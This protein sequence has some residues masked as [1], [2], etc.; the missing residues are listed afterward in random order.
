MGD[1]R[2]HAYKNDNK[3]HWRVIHV[4]QVTMPKL[5]SQRLQQ[6]GNKGTKQVLSVDRVHAN[7]FHWREDLLASILLR[8]PPRK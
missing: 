6:C 4:G 8:R 1:D 2:V 7:K 3:R 5:Y